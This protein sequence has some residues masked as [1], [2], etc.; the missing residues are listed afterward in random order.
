MVELSLNSAFLRVKENRGGPGVDGVR[1]SQFER[2]LERNLNC[3]QNELGQ[4]TYR[5]LPL[6]RILVDK[7]KGT[8]E[9]RALSI[10]AVRDRVAQTAVL[11][12]IAPTTGKDPS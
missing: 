3:L 9:A 5:P 2:H 11:Q 4:K 7:G 8:G 1:I 6:L 12:C 10:P